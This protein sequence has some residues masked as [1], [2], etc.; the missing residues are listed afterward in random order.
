MK[1]VIAALVLICAVVAGGALYTA[2]LIH[3]SEDLSEMNAAVQLSLENNYTD[4]ANREIEHMKKYLADKEQVLSAMGNHNELDNIK[5]NLAELE[6]YA[7]GE[8]VTDALAKSEV[9]EFL[10][11]HMPENYKLTLRNIL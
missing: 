1:S 2:S 9:L 5:I 4:N 11:E 6:Q 8:S 3:V 10:F 7:K